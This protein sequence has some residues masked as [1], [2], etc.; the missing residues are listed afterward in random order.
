M[1]RDCSISI[2]DIF[3]LVFLIGLLNIPDA[4][5]DFFDIMPYIQNQCSKY[6]KYDGKA[7]RQK[8]RINKKQ[9]DFTYRHI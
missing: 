5:S 8:R 1:C 4:Q 2:T 9:P 7:Y 3:H 6:I